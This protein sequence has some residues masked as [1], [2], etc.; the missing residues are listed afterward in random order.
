MRQ[1]FSQTPPGEKEAALALA[2]TR[3]DMIRAG[4]A[5]RQGGI[6][7]GTMLSLGRALGETVAV[8]LIINQVFQ[9]K[10]TVL[11]TGRAT[12]SSTIAAQFGEATGTSSR[13]C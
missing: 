11:E 13:P 5:V 2:S 9:I 10:P 6:I 4:A 7:G 3:W 1:V 12:V 8:L